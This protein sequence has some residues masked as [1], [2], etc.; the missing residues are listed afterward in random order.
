MICEMLRLAIWGLTPQ[1]SEVVE[2]LHDFGLLHVCSSTE[3]KPP[4]KEEE[5]L[6]F[7]R[8]KVLG[9][10]EALD[11]KEWSILTDETIDMARERVD[12]GIDGVVGE[13]DRS[14]D[15]FRQRLASLLDERRRL[16][17]SLSEL[18]RAHQIVFHFIPFVSS[19]DPSERILTLWWTKD[20]T[21]QKTLSAIRA[22]IQK[23]DASETGTRDALRFHVLSTEKEQSVLA[24]SVEKRFADKAESQLRTQG[25]V[26]W[27]APEGSQRATT[28]ES[29]FAVEEGLKE[30]LTRLDNLSEE[31]NKARD[32]WGPRLASLYILLDEKLEEAL[33]ESGSQTRGETFLIEGWIPADSLDE[34]MKLLK[35]RFGDKVLV[36]WRYPSSEEWHRVPALLSNPAATQPF[37]ILLKLMPHPLYQGVDPTTLMAIFFPFFSGCMVGDA[38]YGILIGLLGFRLSRSNRHPLLP[39]VGKILLWICG[40]SIAWGIAFGEF[41]GDLGHR[42]FH[43][44]P[45][46]VERSHAVLPVLI[47]TVALGFAHISIGLFLGF[48][49]GLRKNHRHLWMER[50]G[51]LIVLFSLVGLLVI[52][53]LKLPQPFFSLNI[54]LLVI[55]TALLLAGGKIGGIIETFSAL[56]NVLSYVRIA[57]IGLSSAILAIVATRFVDVLGLSFLGILMALVI[58]LLNFVLAI[59]GSG[60]HSARLHYVEFFSKFY[61]GG[62]KEFRPFSRRRFYWKK[63]C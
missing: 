43:M 7:T 50:L 53:R 28:R 6:K 49:E 25:A 14:L 24:I 56:G 61:L 9:M 59:G 4:S 52:V 42:L 1:R 39:P 21:I 34:A 13:I 38:G 58:H 22:A 8:A 48:M 51:T 40:W 60:L 35:F 17:V 23:L 41:F 47:F 62:G 32:G 10:L 57:A 26:P 16:S 12:L 54:I 29:L 46:W 18:K 5:T 15:A 44:E 36:Q 45:L 20:A 11:W 33:V 31:I 2:A 55:G 37:E 30:T 3:T 63:P 27:R 19:E